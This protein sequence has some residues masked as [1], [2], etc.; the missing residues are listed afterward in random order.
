MS[1]TYGTIQYEST[2]KSGGLSAVSAAFESTAAIVGG[3]NTSE[4]SA[5][6]GEA[7]TLTNSNNVDTLFG[8]ESE[9]AKQVRAA[10]ANGVQTVYAVPLSETTATDSVAGSASG[11]LDHVPAVDPN[12]H[13]EH[14]ITATDTVAA[15]SVT[16]N[17]V[18]DEGTDIATPTE[19]DTIN[20]NPVTGE[21]EADESSDYDIEY[22]YG[23][24]QTAVE[25]ATSLVPRIVGICTANTS[26][27]NDYLTEANTLDT[28]FDFMHGLVGAMPDTEASAYDDAFDDRR[29]SVVASSRGYLDAAETEEVWTVGAVAGR[30][31]AKALGDSTTYED[32][33]G[34][35]SLRTS[36]LNSEV[37][38]LV[39]NQVLPLKQSGGIK[40]IKDM[41][42]STDPQFE[43]IYASEIVDEATEISRRISEN[44][45][46][47]KNTEDNRFLLRESH[48]ASYSEM[49]D[50]DLLEDYYVEVAKGATDFE[51]ELTIGLD[52]IGLMDFINVE[53]VIGDVVRN[54][55][56]A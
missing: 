36:Y 4:G 30:Q 28:D 38:T 3:M 24:F 21:W 50:D 13:P 11:V 31:A 33:Q 46:S 39:D 56:V 48:D 45:I 49:D 44:F 54:G 27:A 43:R 53:I 47:D 8:D 18:Y 25:T 40:L 26:V 14:D 19:A 16:V 10:F 1:E 6:E 52:V 23:D 20:L 29:L 15:S 12:V 42:T 7:Q 17:I 34:L 9:L 32:I 37:Q 5:T 51:V 41:T 22:T 55:G 2:V 35:S